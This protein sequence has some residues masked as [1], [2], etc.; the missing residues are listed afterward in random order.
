[1]KIA[2]KVSHR[3]VL[4]LTLLIASFLL[5]G[6]CSFRTLSHL[7]VNGP[8]YQRIVQGKDLI[9]DIL[10]PPEYIIESYLTSLQLLEATSDDRKQL[11]E[12]FQALK[13]DY[14]ERHKFWEGQHL[15]GSL[16]DKFKVADKPARAF[17][18]IAFDQFIP[19][20]EKN[21]VATAK[22]AL[23]NMKQYYNQHRAAINSLV[24]ATTKSNELD[25][26]NAQEELLTAKW[27]ML[28]ILL[29]SVGCVSIFL[30]V[31]ARSL[32]RQLGGE[33]AYAVNVVGQ[34]ADGNL[35]TNIEIKSGDCTSLLFSIK[36]MRDSLTDI[37]AKVRSGTDTIATASR[38]IAIGNH[39]LSSRTEQQ[40]G[41][42]EESVSSIEELSLTVARNAENSQQA[43]ELA[44]SASEVAIQGGSVISKVIETMGSINDSSKKIVDIISVIDGI[45]FQTNILALNAAVEAARAGE[46]GR[47]FAVVASEVRGLAQRS[48]SAAKEIKCLI[49]DSVD[50]VDA[51]SKLVDQAGST[52]QDIVESIGRVSNI[53]KEI[54]AASQEQTSDIEQIN[55]AVTQMDTMTRQNAALVEEAAAA[56]TAMEDQAANLSD[57]VSTFKIG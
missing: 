50:K 22:V 2:L 56:S 39:D 23:E 27:L 14:E 29:G 6:V 33:P 38:Q 10:P 41:G 19:A 4:L 51:G 37:V 53:V 55:Q 48:A 32:L 11:I 46:Q 42:L 15:E 45:A 35:A 54:T 24:D 34:I 30:Y 36:V 25:E 12:K 9:G 5:Y 13:T 44:I 57:L 49:E 40:A 47:G 18:R 17:Y 28:T 8:I 16:L 43:N 26:K 21:D 31:I 3:F 20:L 7:Q 1:M 52:M